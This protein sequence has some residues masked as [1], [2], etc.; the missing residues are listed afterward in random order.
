MSCGSA[1]LLRE[2]YRRSARGESSW[3]ALA[4]SS[5]PVPVSPRIR[6]FASVGATILINENTS[7]MA[8]LSP[9]MRA[10]ESFTRVEGRL[11]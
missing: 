7:C 1:A 4:T 11:R 10:V 3:M 5:L 8:L 6:T 2:T 9:M